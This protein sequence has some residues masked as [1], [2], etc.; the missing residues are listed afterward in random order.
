LTFVIVYQYYL[1]WNVAVFVAENALGGEVYVSDDELGFMT[2]SNPKSQTQN[3][4]S[5]ME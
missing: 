4:D 3:T 1:N 2:P 5:K